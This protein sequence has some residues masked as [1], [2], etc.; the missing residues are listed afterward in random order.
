MSMQWEHIILYFVVPILFV[1]AVTYVI[2]F[3]DKEERMDKKFQVRFK[4]QFL[5]P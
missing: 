4:L 3:W 5:N 2:L 1:T